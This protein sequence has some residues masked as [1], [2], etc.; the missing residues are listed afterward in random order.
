MS[1]D[2]S[3]TQLNIFDY[4][5]KNDLNYQSLHSKIEIKE[6]KEIEKF[7]SKVSTQIE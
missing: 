4:N 6:K 7:Y 3:L 1:S 5:T 2:V